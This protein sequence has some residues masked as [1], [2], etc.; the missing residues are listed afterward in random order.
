METNFAQAHRLAIIL[1]ALPIVRSTSVM[2]ILRWNFIAALLLPNVGIPYMCL[3]GPCGT[4]WAE[5]ERRRMIEQ[6]KG[7]TQ[8]TD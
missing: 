1:L 8:D 5:Q 6:T 7:Q 4:I 2:S 3:E